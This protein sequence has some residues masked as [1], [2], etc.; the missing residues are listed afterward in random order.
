MIRAKLPSSVAICRVCA[1]S[2]STVGQMVRCS[3]GHES[4][5]PE[6][7]YLKLR[8]GNAQRV[9]RFRSICSSSRAACC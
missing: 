6:R 7:P 4:P 9:A 2:V 8:A 1:N 5:L 3:N